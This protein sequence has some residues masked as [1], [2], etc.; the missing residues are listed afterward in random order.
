MPIRKIITSKVGTKTVNLIAS[1]VLI[2][3]KTSI[4][5]NVGVAAAGAI[6]VTETGILQTKVNELED[7]KTQV[8]TKVG[9]VNDQKKVVAGAI[10]TAAGLVSLAYLLAYTIWIAL[11]FILSK[12]P[13]GAKIPNQPTG[14]EAKQST[15]LGHVVISRDAVKD[16]P[17]LVLETIG[18]PTVMAGYYAANPPIMT[19]K[20]VVVTP[21]T[22]GVPTY[23]ILRPV[24]GK[25]PGPDSSPEGGTYV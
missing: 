22:I 10:N 15:F 16:V 17:C 24:N 6:V 3:G 9:E 2:G 14:V 8:K 21:K 5:P 4:D 13:V 11:G 20:N 18:A 1:G 23:W 7:L 12:I 25:G 19:G